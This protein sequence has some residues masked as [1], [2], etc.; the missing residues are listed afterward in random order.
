[1]KGAQ[2]HWFQG[3]KEFNLELMYFSEDRE[4]L[5]SELIRIANTI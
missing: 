4:E 1:M 3:E 2:L 5:K